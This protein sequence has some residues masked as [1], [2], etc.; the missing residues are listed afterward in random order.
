MKKLGKASVLLRMI[1][2]VKPLA[3]FMILAVV[4][5]TLGFLCAQFIPILG[6]IA[7]VRGIG[8]EST[9]SLTPIFTVLIVIAVLRAALKLA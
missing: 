1:K 2:L 7:V 4:M 6:G 8:Q 9:A 5:G 3:G